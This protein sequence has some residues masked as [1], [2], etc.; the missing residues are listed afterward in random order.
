V[1]LEADAHFLAE[2][3]YI[4]YSVSRN[5]RNSLGVL[6]MGAIAISMVHR[7]STSEALQ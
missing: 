7:A 1:S 6:A 5:W 2:L 3:K 4:A